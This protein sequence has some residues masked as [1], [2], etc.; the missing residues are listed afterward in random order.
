MWILESLK[1]QSELW[2]SPGNLFLKKATNPVVTLDQHL[3]DPW[4]TV[5]RQLVMSQ[6]SANQV[7]IEDINQHSTMDAFS[8]YM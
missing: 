7:L 1:N 5:N 3:D 6:P 8:T 2:K 4:S